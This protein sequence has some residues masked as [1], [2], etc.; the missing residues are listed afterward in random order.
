MIMLLL[1][2]HHNV[3]ANLSFVQTEQSG[4]DG[5]ERYLQLCHYYL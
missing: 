1:A 4:D 2:D 5:D 3:E